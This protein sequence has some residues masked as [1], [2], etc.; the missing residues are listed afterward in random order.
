MRDSG[1]ETNTVVVAHEQ[2]NGRGQMGTYWESEPGKNLTFSVLKK[3]KDSKVSNQFYLSILVCLSVY[4]TLNHLKIPD[5]HIKWPNDILSGN[6]KICG[7]L[8][9]PIVGGDMV[10]SAIIGIGLNVNQ[11]NFPKLS[12]VSSLKL[13]AGNSFD[14]DQVL[15]LALIKLEKNFRYLTDLDFEWLLT[16]FENH[17][18]MKDET[19]SFEFKD[20]TL[21]E[22]RIRGITKEGKLRV[23]FDTKAIFEFGFKEVKLIY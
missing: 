1:L 23:E 5:V 10:K 7:V 15:H 12:N 11:I 2:Y 13:L 9:E 4:E 16:K 21:K 19:A 8:I 3:F 14:K 17:L 20:G 6:Q 18:Y 22:G